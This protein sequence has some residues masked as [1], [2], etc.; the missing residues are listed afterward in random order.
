VQAQDGSWWLVFL[1]YR[2]FGGAYHHLGRETF[3]AP[4][5]WDEGEWPMVNEG[6]AVDARIPGQL[7]PFESVREPSTAL[8]TPGV[9]WMYLQNPIFENYDFTEE[10]WTLHPHGTLLANDRPTYVGRRQEAARILLQTTV[11]VDPKHQPDAY[12]LA[13]YQIH[14]GQ[15][16]LCVQGDEVQVIC[17]LKNMRTVVARQGGL[18]GKQVTL[19][20]R[21]DEDQ[22]HFLY[23]TDGG[24]QYEELAQLDVTL[25]STEIAGGFTGVTVGV[26]A[27]GNETQPAARF[28]QVRYW[29]ERGKGLL[30]PTR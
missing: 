16:Q 26:F 12:G 5:R 3:L 29:E 14:N 25:V 20:I 7:L 9:E 22:Y 23:S 8:A 28:Q 2:Q 4:V 21:A 19:L 24:S 13:V 15:L 30:P 17:Y 6:L 1:A 10:A 18:K 27:E 11:K